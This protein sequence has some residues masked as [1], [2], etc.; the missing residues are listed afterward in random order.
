MKLNLK[1][2]KYLQGKQYVKLNDFILIGT[3]T[4]IENTARTKCGSL[5]TQQNNNKSLIRAFEKISIY[6]N[7]NLP[8]T[9][10]LL[11]ESNETVNE[12]C[13]GSSISYNF[14]IDKSLRKDWVIK[15]LKV[16]KNIYSKKQIETVTVFKYRNAIRC[17]SELLTSI[18]KY[19]LLVKFFE[20]KVKSKRCD[21]NT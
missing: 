7:C 21:L 18:G 2:Y 13:I 15:A 3:R 19:S 10:T 12:L 20:H 6:R 9:N 4:Q 16:N 17:L 5:L 11:L 14:S 1:C 8:F